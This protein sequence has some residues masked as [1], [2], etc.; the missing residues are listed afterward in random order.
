GSETSKTSA[1][2]PA[3]PPPDVTA[4]TS[5]PLNFE[6]PAWRLLRAATGIDWVIA[7]KL[8]ARKRPRLVPVYDRVV[9]CAYRTRSGFWRWLHCKLREDS[10]IL[11]QRLDVLH[12]EAGLPPRSADFGCLMSCSGWGTATT[13]F[14]MAVS[15]S[16]CR[17][18]GPDKM[19]KVT[20]HID[21]DN[22]ER[23]ADIA[24]AIWAQMNATGYNFS[25]LLDSTADAAAVDRRWDEYS[26]VSWAA[27]GRR[28]TPQAVAVQ[29]ARNVGRRSAGTKK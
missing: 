15:A 9:S 7:G 27:G 23:Y 28:G 6:E 22:D 3:P 26:E 1:Y 16:P 13:T 10:G 20:V 5:T 24:N 17:T 4:D 11:M 12:K 21:C 29:A 14:P 25:I 18:R 2:A 19:R 8:L